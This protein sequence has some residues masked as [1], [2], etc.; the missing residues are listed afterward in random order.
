MFNNI[1]HQEQVTS[2]LSDTAALPGALLFS[3]PDYSGKL[4]TALELARV[5]SC[6]D[7]ANRA[8]WGCNCASCRSHRLL[9]SPNIQ[10]LGARYFIQDLGAALD[11]LKKTQAPAGRF[12]FIRGIKKLLKRFDPLLWEGEEKRIQKQLKPVAELYELLEAFYPGRDLPKDWQKRA[13]K[14]H[15]LACDISSAVSRDTIPI[16][17]IRK[18]STWC[19]TSSSHGPKF[20]I[21]ENADRMQDAPRNALLKI[22]EE[23][24]KNVYF[25]LLTKRRSAMIPTVLSRVRS[26]TFVERRQ[27]AVK[28]VLSRVFRES[29]PEY[30]NLAE[31]FRVFQAHNPGAMERVK[32]EI[33]STLRSDSDWQGLEGFQLSKNREDQQIILQSLSEYYNDAL[34]NETMSLVVIEKAKNEIKEAQNALELYNMGG[35]M[36]FRNLFYRLKSMK[37]YD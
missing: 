31:Y 37:A 26:F 2:L 20:V 17:M 23:P 25:I 16:H 30:A 21:I 9:D 33:T 7:Q 12:F 4:T 32:D 6:Y 28:D 18:I 8:P 5:L 27:E 14:I 10:I 19:H 15:K 3:G 36:V 24:P 29:N 1:L 13:E 34:R 11:V 35:D 22:L